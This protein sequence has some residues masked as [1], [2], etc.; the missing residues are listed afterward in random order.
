ME[1]H[2]HSHTPG[3]RQVYLALLLQVGFELWQRR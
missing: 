2:Y 1:G 3:L